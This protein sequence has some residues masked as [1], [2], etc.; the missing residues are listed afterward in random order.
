MPE[1]LLSFEVCQPI[2]EHARLIMAWRNDPA[3]L[4][5]SYHREAKVWESFWPEYRTTYFSGYP[6]PV[7]I[8]SEGERVG[9]IRYKRVAHP[10]GW[11]GT[12]VDISINLAPERRRKGVGQAA[13]RA[14]GTYLL[15][16][17]GIDSIYAEVRQ[18]NEASHRTFLGAGFVDLG[19]KTKTV[20]DTG[21]TCQIRCYSAELT[22][23]FWRTRPV[24]IVAEAGSNWRMGTPARD[25]AMGRTL[26]EVAAA[27]G[28]DAIKFQ[29]YRPETVYVENA[30][31]SDYLAE[32]GIKQDIREIFAD[33]AM[34]YE[35]LTD[36]A[37]Y[38]QQRKIDFLSTGFSPQDFAAIDPLVSV[39][40]IASYE[41]SHPHL[42]ALAG[43]SSKPLILSTGASG[44]EEI[45]W[46]V[47][48]FHQAG[49]CDLC[50]LQC[51][52]D[53]PAPVSSLNL[54]TLPWLHRRFGV[55]VGLSDHSREPA[56]GP[57]V[58]VGLGARVIEKHFTL[59]NRLPGPD[60]SFALLPDELKELVR[61][62]RL[63]EASLGDGVKRVLSE[64]QELAGFARRGLQAIKDVVPGEILR[65][66]VNYAVLRPGKQALGVHPRNRGQ[67]EGRRAT[68]QIP[69]GDGLRLGDGI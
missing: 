17:H 65:E 63:A 40:K 24:Y 43:K 31:Q 33:L 20:P 37:N 30:G 49:G 68:R 66:G 54:D 26:I 35:M 27:A 45:A 25:Q 50:L 4:S 56:V 3:T 69:A 53:Y 11:H 38:C 67:L 18:E 47:E 34:P 7:F 10:K 19:P 2:P 1:A 16:E 62:V 61:Q 29:T 39:H 59:D 51:T 44:E 32:A 28:A 8:L 64:E 58:A 22:S 48:T 57:I 23:S 42:L 9:F 13:L 12:T 14:A 55:A 60:H 41:I 6:H 52:A 5:M 36:L 46:A 15:H 21:E